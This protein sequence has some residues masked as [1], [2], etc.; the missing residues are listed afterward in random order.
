M[1]IP[2]RGNGDFGQEQSVNS[3]WSMMGNQ[4]R[5]NISSSVGS[6]NPLASDSSSSS[7]DDDFMDEEMEDAIYSTPQVSK[8]SQPLGNSTPGMGNNVVPWMP[9]SSSAISIFFL[10]L[11]IIWNT[12]YLSSSLI[13]FNGKENQ[14]VV[15]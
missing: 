4:E 5:M 3:L 9:G 6:T 1:N 15:P 11:S 7:G 2:G 13:N 14:K 10:S 12:P 8:N